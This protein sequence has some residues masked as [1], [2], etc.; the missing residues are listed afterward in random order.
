MVKLYLVPLRGSPNPSSI[1]R[2]PTGRAGVLHFGPTG[3]GRS[4]EMGTYLTDRDRRI[5]G[6]RIVE[7]EDAFRSVHDGVSEVWQ[8]FAN[9]HTILLKALTSRQ[10]AQTYDPATTRVSPNAPG[11]AFAMY[12]WA[13]VHLPA[14]AQPGWDDPPADRQVEVMRERL[15]PL[16]APQRVGGRDRKVLEGLTHLLSA[17]AE[18]GMQFPQEFIEEATSRCD[19]LAMWIETASREETESRSWEEFLEL[20]KKWDKLYRS[21]RDVTAGYLWLADRSEE[22]STLFLGSWAGDDEGE[23]E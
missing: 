18:G 7:M 11:R 22:M 8:H 14:L 3:P 1:I 13:Y 2:F 6:E 15:F 9:T 20:R 4:F 16:G 23:E 17:L 19:D 21:L 12:R 10:L 5:I